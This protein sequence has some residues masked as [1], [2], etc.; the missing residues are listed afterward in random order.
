MKGGKLIA[1]G[2][3]TCIFKPNIICDNSDKNNNKISKLFLKKQDNIN[4]EINFNKLVNKLKNNNNWSV[5]LHEKCISPKWND[6]YSQDKDIKTCLDKN[7]YSK[8]IFNNNDHLMLYG[9]YG[10]EDMESYFEKLFRGNLYIM[11]N[12]KINV[13]L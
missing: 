8:Y 10:G 2:S 13:H 9:D 1:T 3:K 4:E 5:T 12:C 7:I 11:K 6:F